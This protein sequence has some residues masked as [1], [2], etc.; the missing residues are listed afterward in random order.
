[1]TLLLML[2]SYEALGVCVCVCARARALLLCSGDNTM[3][4]RTDN[5]V[6]DSD[7]SPGE[8]L[9]TALREAAA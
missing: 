2:R 3:I 5:S 7:A 6:D 8:R 4:T 9:A 1:M